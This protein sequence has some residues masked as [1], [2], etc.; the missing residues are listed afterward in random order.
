MPDNRRRHANTVPIA[1]F[2]VSLVIALFVLVAGLGYMWC[3]NQIYTTGT[4]I[5]K[6]EDELRQL[7]SR[8]EVASTNI[9]KHTSTAELQKRL[10]SGFINLRRITGSEVVLIAT[11]PRPAAPGELRPVANERK[12][13]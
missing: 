2:I 4:Q 5:K 1:K 6:H 3:K 10:D 8:N 12:Q 13:E 9:A 7:R 11:K